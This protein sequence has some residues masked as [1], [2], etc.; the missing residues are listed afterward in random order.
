MPRPPMYFD[1][2]SM[3]SANTYKLI[4]S[5]VVPRPIAWLVTRSPAGTLNA[6]PFSFFNAFS[7]APPVIA[8][9]IAPHPTREKDSFSNIETQGEFVV[10]MVPYALAGAMNTTAVDF[11]QGHDELEVAGLATLPSEKIAVPRIAASPVAYECRLQQIVDIN[12][13]NRLVL[14]RVVA[15]HIDDAA[16]LDPERCHIDTAR[17]DLIGRTRSPGGYVRLSDAFEMPLRNHAQ[18]QAEQQA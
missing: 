9:G 12:A 3:S 5:T 16:V 14:G 4:A 17:L 8:L 7:G 10:N 18:W 2:E 15:I 13:P 11:P 1:P 6:A